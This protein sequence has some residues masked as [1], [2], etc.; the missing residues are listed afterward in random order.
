MSSGYLSDCVVLKRIYSHVNSIHIQT[1]LWVEKE[2]QPQ[3]YI[4]NEEEY[5]FLSLEEWYGIYQEFE[6]L[7]TYQ[8]C[9]NNTY[10]TSNLLIFKILFCDKRCSIDFINLVLEAFNTFILCINLSMVELSADYIN[11]LNFIKKVK[12][13]LRFI[14]VPS[15]ENLY[16]KLNSFA[17][18][19]SLIE[20]EIVS[21]G[22][23]YF[24]KFLM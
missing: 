18:P 16:Y 5:F 13:K 24:E 1:G 3:V 14:K 10:D 8:V 22:S 6:V 12:S 4:F 9:F 11:A 20:L 17:C 23:A 15:L 19:K 2:F 7:R 21:V